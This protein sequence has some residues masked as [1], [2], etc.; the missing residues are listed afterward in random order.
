MVNDELLTCDICGETIPKA[1]AP[2]SGWG[3]YG[4]PSETDMIARME[5]LQALP[6]GE[7]PFARLHDAQLSMR[8]RLCVMGS[9]AAS[10]QLDLNEYPEFAEGL[11]HYRQALVRKEQSS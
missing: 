8:C 4:L 9:I 2:G 6:E 1:E 3:L 11:D 5:Q 10:I 7:N